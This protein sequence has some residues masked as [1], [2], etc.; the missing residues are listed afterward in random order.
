MASLHKI[1]T[2]SFALSLTVISCQSSPQGNLLNPNAFRAAVNDE[3]EEVL[4]DVRTPEEYNEG[5]IKGALNLDWNNENFEREAAQLDR[6]KPLFVYCKSGGRS[7]AATQALR[8]MGFTRVYELEGGIKKWQKAGMPIEN[9]ADSQP[10]GMTMKEYHALLETEKLVLV[11]FYAPW[12]TPCK[13]MEPFLQ[14]IAG[15]KADVLDLHKIN[16][17]KNTRVVAE[18]NVSGLPTVLLYKNKK[19]VW[20]HI[21]YIGKDELLEKISTFN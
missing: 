14:E 17:D 6:D 5:H 18:L 4:L 16:A 11:D 7:A 20:S 8:N 15:E 19:L 13:K 10:T 3:R 12:C 21:G 1:L 9:G 2:L